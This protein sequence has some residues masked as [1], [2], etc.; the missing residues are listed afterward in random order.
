[1]SN[2]VVISFDTT[3][4]MYPCLTEVRSS[5]KEI[6]TRLFKEVPG[7]RMGIVAHGDYCDE[8]SSYL[9][10]HV[11][12]CTDKDKLIDFV[13]TVGNTSGGDYPEAYE[14]VLREVQKFDWS[15]ETLRAL[16]IIGDATPHTAA[17]SPYKIDWK[18][19][20]SEL[21][22]MGINIYSVQALNCGDAKA[23]TFY[24][25]MAQMTNGYH[26]FLDQFSYI[27]DMLLAICFKQA[28]E[29]QLA[30]YEQEVIARKYGMNLSIRKMFDTMLGRKSDVPDVDV[31]KYDADSDKLTAC[32][33]SK[34]QVLTVDKDTSIKD[35]VVKK[36]LTFKTGKG[37]YEFTK[38]EKIGADKEVV[39]MKKDTG[40]LF[41]G[42]HA[43]KIIGLGTES[44]RYKPTDVDDYRVF[45]QSTS[46]NRKLIADTGFLYEVD[47][48]GITA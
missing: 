4:S 14:Y 5:I 25:Q 31:T 36:G 22:K 32:P 21:N 8:K 47:G 2:D 29:E 3:G 12:L 38:P 17:Q 44:K 26:L 13:N 23:Y 42:K 39:L 7:I 11:D 45:I 10:K 33:A 30:K 35:F 15:S 43:R 6:V 41:E 16:V 1:M 19:E 9:M 46:Y 40:E 37:Y 24:K 28:G 27:R 48:W 18:N 34:Y 20:V